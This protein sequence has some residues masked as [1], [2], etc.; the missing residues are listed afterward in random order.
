[1]LSVSIELILV[2]NQDVQYVLNVIDTFSCASARFE[3]TD[4]ENLH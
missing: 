1:M 2:M 3:E 4:L